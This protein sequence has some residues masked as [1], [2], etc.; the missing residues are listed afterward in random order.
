MG[1]TDAQSKRVVLSC[2]DEN[3]VAVEGHWVAKNVGPCDGRIVKGPQQ[4]AGS[5]IEQ[6]G[7]T[8]SVLDNAIIESNAIIAAGAVVT[9]G[10]HVESGSVYAGSPAKKIKELSPELLEGEINRIADSYAM[11]ASWYK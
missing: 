5:Y 3:I 8:D 2:T 4:V 1:L 11:Y 9:K 10:T 7:L 6:V